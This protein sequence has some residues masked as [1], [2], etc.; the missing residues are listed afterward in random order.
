MRQHPIVIESSSRRVSANRN[1]NARAVPPLS[2]SPAHAR[3]EAQ[4]NVDINVFDWVTLVIVRY[5]VRRSV[6]PAP[7]FSRQSRI[8]IIA[9]MHIEVFLGEEF[10]TLQFGTAA[11]T[12][13]GEK[14]EENRCRWLVH[15][16]PQEWS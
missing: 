5:C 16:D 6:N 8:R 9:A 12:N 1:V 15:G 11:F 4:F 10:N 14:K 3:A 2:M 13:Q 7:D